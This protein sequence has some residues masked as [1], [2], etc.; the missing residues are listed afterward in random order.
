MLYIHQNGKQHEQLLWQ[1]LAESHAED[2]VPTSRKHAPRATPSKNWWKVR[3]AKSGRTT[4]MSLATP[5]DT[6][7]STCPHKGV[8]NIVSA[9]FKAEHTKRVQQKQL[10]C[11]DT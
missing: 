6:P 7:I 2:Q 9:H 3:A 8:I 4:P 1:S 11:V 10:L 5:R